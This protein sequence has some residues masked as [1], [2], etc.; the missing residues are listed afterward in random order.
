[1]AFTSPM[2]SLFAPPTPCRSQ[3]GQTL[4]MVT[5][6]SHGTRICVDGIA[7]ADWA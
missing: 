5:R 4:A 6:E 2:T 3:L 1:M 7:L